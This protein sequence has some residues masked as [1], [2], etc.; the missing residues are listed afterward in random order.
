MEKIDQTV[1]RGKI[2]GGRFAAYSL[3]VDVSRLFSEYGLEY[4]RQTMKLLLA[5]EFLKDEPTPERLDAR[6]KEVLVKTVSKAAYRL[7]LSEVKKLVAKGPDNVIEVVREVMEGG[8]D[9]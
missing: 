2:E 9:K 8:D 6:I 7:A 5:E 3:H 4:I 1:V